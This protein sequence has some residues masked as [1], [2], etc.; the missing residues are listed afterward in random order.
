GRTISGFAT[1][2]ATSQPIPGAIVQARG[3]GWEDLAWSGGERPAAWDVS[4]SPPSAEVA[5]DEHGEF[6]FRGLSRGSFEIVAAAEGYSLDRESR[7][8]VVEAG[9]ENVIL[10]FRVARWI[11]LAAIDDVDESVVSSAEFE[12]QM[13]NTSPW[14]VG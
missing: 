13:P 3:R 4:P 10:K 5:C 14:R 12:V 6:R 8:V 9:A 1:D 2:A 11:S 7:G